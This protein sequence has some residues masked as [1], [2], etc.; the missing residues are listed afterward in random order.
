MAAPINS[1]PAGQKSKTL[2]WVLGILA[3]LLLIGGIAAFIWRNKMTDSD[4][5]GINGEEPPPPPPPP[6]FTTSINQY[7]TLCDSRVSDACAEAKCEP[8]QIFTISGCVLYDKY[9]GCAN[10]VCNNGFTCYKD[11]C[12][13]KDVFDAY[14]A[15]NPLGRISA[16]YRNSGASHKSIISKLFN[17]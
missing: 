12:V 7:G 6:L 11:L 9:R 10:G 13:Q 14:N 15:A 8:H 1:A 16:S 4:N 2:Y 3:G 5:G 17:T